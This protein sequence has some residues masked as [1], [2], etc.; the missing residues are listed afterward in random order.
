MKTVIIDA[1][2]HRHQGELVPAGTQI[3][4]N[5]QTANWMIEKKIARLAPVTTLS[6][7]EN[8]E[9]KKKDK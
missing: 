5:D 6:A 2:N 3:T 4:V 7:A 1:S 9:T 8:P